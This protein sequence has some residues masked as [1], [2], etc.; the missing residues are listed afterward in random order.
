MQL[1]L[2]SSVA[3]LH[4]LLSGLDGGDISGN[5]ATDDNDILLLCT[6]LETAQSTFRSQSQTYQPL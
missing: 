2:Y 1:K 5:T 3:Y 6:T 4:A